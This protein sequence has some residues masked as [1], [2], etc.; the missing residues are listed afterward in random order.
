MWAQFWKVFW[1]DTTVSSP[2]REEK[3][4][5]QSTEFKIILICEDNQNEGSRNKNSVFKD[6]FILFWIL[7]DQR[8]FQLFFNYPMIWNITYNKM[9][10]L[11]FCRDLP[12]NPRSSREVCRR[13]LQAKKKRLSKDNIHFW[14]KI[15]YL[16]NKGSLQVF[17][18]KYIMWT[19][20]KYKMINSREVETNQIH[21][22]TQ[23]LVG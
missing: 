17:V 19:S 8:E 13:P 21:S 14:L 12:P 2:K 23:A 18:K 7:R 5:S 9:P 10:H 20:I 22:S 6:K 15:I 11:V 3:F 4:F 1:I 16:P